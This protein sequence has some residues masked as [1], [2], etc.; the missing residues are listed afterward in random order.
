MQNVYSKFPGVGRP[1]SPEMVGLGDPG[2]MT[3][4]GPGAQGGAGRGAQILLGGAGRGAQFCAPVRPCPPWGGELRRGEARRGEARRGDERIA[5][6]V[7]WHRRLRAQ[8]G[9]ARPVHETAGRE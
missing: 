3:R 4:V 9:P 1:A 6:G 8:P 2:A 7:W 5:V